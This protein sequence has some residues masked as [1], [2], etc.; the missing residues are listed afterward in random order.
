MNHIQQLSA[1]LTKC[2]NAAQQLGWTH[3]LTRCLYNIVTSLESRAHD[4]RRR[5]THD[6]PDLPKL[7]ERVQVLR[8]ARYSNHVHA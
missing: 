1:N 7:T 4:R 5:G 8:Q 2:E 6:H 3:P